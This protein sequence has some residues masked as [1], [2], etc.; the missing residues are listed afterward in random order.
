MQVNVAI[1]LGPDET[2]PGDLTEIAERVLDTLGGDPEV[3]HCSV[4]VT[5]APETAQVGASP[6]PAAPVAPPPAPPPPPPPEDL[7]PA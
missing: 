7:P 3:D 4:I 1:T 6:V 2:S 5:A